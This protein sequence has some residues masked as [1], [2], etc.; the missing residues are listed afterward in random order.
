MNAE[1]MAQFE[2]YKRIADRAIED[3][4]TRVGWDI[5]F[6]RKALQVLARE[7]E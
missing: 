3:G 5:A 4:A 7:A 2:H 1:E 6:C